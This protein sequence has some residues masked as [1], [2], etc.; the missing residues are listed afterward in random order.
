ML[1]YN[2]S[3]GTSYVHVESSSEGMAV[4]VAAKLPQLPH[5]FFHSVE[6]LLLQDL[7]VKFKR[8]RGRETEREREKEGGREGERERVKWF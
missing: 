4:S 2:P 5:F 7:R 8:E 3:Y 6:M 1:T